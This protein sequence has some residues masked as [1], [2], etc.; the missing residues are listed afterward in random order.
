MVRFDTPDVLL[1]EIIGLHARTFADKPALTCAGVTIGWRDFDARLGAFACHLQSLGVGRG[2]R[3]GVLADP[4]ADAICAEFGA[5]RAGASV[6]SLPTIVAPDSLAAM[7]T[8]SGAKVL[9]V[10]ESQREIV[11]RIRG[12]LGDVLPHGYIVIG[13]SAPHWHDFDSAVR[14]APARQGPRVQVSGEDEFCVIYSSGTTSVPKG[15]VLTH[16]C[17]LM[18]ALMTSSEFGYNAR[19]VVVVAAALHSNTAWSLL[20]RGFLFGATVVLMTRFDAREFC[21]LVELHKVTHTTLVPAQIRR[22][23]EEPEAAAPGLSSIRTLCSTGS[24]MPPVLKK[25]VIARFP[26]AF[27]EVYGLTEGIAAILKPEDMTLHADS[28]GRPAIGNDIRILDADDHEGPPG[29]VGEIVGYGPQLMNRYD[30]APEKTAQSIWREPASGR[31]YL[32]SGDVGYFDADGFLHLV[33]RKKDMIVS[34]GSNVFPADIEGVLG[35]HPDIREACVFGMPDPKWGETPVALVVPAATMR[36]S[37]EELRAWVN[38]NLGKHQ[39]V[40]VVVFREHLPRNAGGKILKQ[41]LR[42]EFLAATQ[43]TGLDDPAG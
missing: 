15:I 35:T 30:N 33:D 23:L 1:P 27:H 21:R 42:S 28:A 37:T 14:A 25:R 10:T 20:I 32:R 29:T 9:V 40:S 41:A 31:T 36:A 13:G 18:T 3:V 19:S 17:R 8:D 16:R 22:I 4:C 12:R 7:I 34:G 26:Q 24:F 39:R 11:D 38:R 43:S 5:L 6:A 2:S